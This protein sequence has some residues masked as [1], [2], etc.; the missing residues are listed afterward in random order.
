[1][2][3]V[4]VR[5][6]TH[7]QTIYTSIIWSPK[8][9]H[10]ACMVNVQ[11][12][13]GVNRPDLGL[14]VLAGSCTGRR[15][16]SASDVQDQPWSWRQLWLRPILEE[17]LQL[18][19]QSIV[20][21]KQPSFPSETRNSACRILNIWTFVPDF[22]WLMVTGSNLLRHC[23]DVSSMSLSNVMESTPCFTSRMWRFKSGV[24]S[25]DELCSVCSNSDA[26][27]LEAALTLAVT[28]SIVLSMRESASCAETEPVLQVS[29]K[30]SSS[31][32]AIVSNLSCSDQ[33]RWYLFVD[34][35]SQ[36]RKKL[37]YSEQQV[38][39]IVR[40]VALLFYLKDSRTVYSVHTNTVTCPLHQWRVETI[41]FLLN[42]HNQQ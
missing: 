3:E 19:Q 14:T 26:T 21:F 35:D 22:S 4:L 42:S 33:R 6:I 13:E 16:S 27:N 34:Q 10:H 8:K 40:T 37:L 11:P 36:Q 1:M 12:I 39:V 30:S 28:S 31:G 2:V 38:A 17:F 9:R 24:R 41:S 29:Q 5:T 23:A 32:G 7:G 20:T 25:F 18:L 15:C